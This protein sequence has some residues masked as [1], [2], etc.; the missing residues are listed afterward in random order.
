[1]TAFLRRLLSNPSPYPT[2]YSL[3]KGDGDDL[4]NADALINRANERVVNGNLEGALADFEDAIALNPNQATAFFNR[5]VLIHSLGKLE[6]AIQDFSAAIALLPDYDEPYYQRGNSYRQLG[7]FHQAIQDY[8]QAIRINPYCIKAYYQ[9]ADSRAELGDH[10]GALADYSQVILLV[11]KDA[12]AYCQ[13]GIFLSQSGELTK[14]VADFTAAIERNPRFADAYFHRGYCWAQLGDAQQ[15]SQDFSETLLHNPNHQAALTRAYAVGMLKESFPVLP[16]HQPLLSASKGVETSYAL[17]TQ[18]ESIAIPVESMPAS[19]IAEKRTPTAKTVDH[20]FLQ[21]Q[22]RCQRGDLE[23]AITDYSQIIQQDPH[24]TQAYYQRS[25]SFRA[26]GKTEAAMKDL[27]QAIHWTRVHSLELMRHFSRELSTTL[28]RLKQDLAEWSEYSSLAQDSF[29]PLPKSSSPS[30]TVQSPEPASHRSSS[31]LPPAASGKSG[32]ASGTLAGAIADYTHA[33]EQNP[34][35]RE[36]FFQ[37]GQRRA[38]AGDLQGAI[39]DYSRTLRLAPNHSEAYLQRAHCRAVLG[40]DIGAQADLNEVI[41]RKSKISPTPSTPLP[42]Q[43]SHF[44]PSFPPISAMENTPLNVSSLPAALPPIKQPC[45]HA[46]NSPS[47]QFCIHCGQPL[48]NLSRTRLRP[49]MT[50]RGVATS[51]KI[52]PASSQRQQRLKEAEGFYN[53]GVMLWQQGNRQG[54]LRAL[55]TGLK[56]FLEQREIRRYQQTLHLMQDVAH[57]LNG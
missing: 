11:P 55:S 31:A 49:A 5:G 22:D 8:T 30:Q 3:G 36:V 9:R 26:L 37:R 38:L 17:G 23:G 15:A 25:Q 4:K 21:A 47:N 50:D 33:L 46:G 54:S 12:N 28:E 24:N 44:P 20:W 2:S 16:N 7:Q 1:M 39:A 6:A 57:A 14:A 27:N 35:D 51:T 43:P 10:P 42:S 32:S 56:I 48:K 52:K 29:Q 40:D 41:R 53:Q 19:P 34:P 45:N 13:R 18:K